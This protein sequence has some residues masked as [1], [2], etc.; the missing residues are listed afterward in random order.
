MISHTWTENGTIYFKEN[1]DLY[2]HIMSE[3]NPLLHEKT[4]LQINLQDPST[5]NTPKEINHKPKNETNPI[6]EATGK[7][8]LL[9]KKSEMSSSGFTISVTEESDKEQTKDKLKPRR[10][11]KNR[12]ESE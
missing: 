1:T 7:T 8:E 3:N 9:T 5:L 6:H 12:T 11:K 4:D 2:P 10:K